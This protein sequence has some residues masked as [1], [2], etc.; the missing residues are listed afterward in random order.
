[1]PRLTKQKPTPL[2]TEPDRALSRVLFRKNAWILGVAAGVILVLFLLVQHNSNKRAAF[3]EADQGADSPDAIIEK[4]HL[5]STALAQKHWELYATSAKLYQNL[6]RADTEDIYAEY[7][8]NNRMVSN[9]TADK[10]QINT[11]TNATLV[12]G[13]VELITENGSKL[14]TDKLAW[15]PD[16]DQIRTNEKVHVYKGSDDITAVGLVADT[17][18]NNIQF[19]K[20]VHTQVRDTNEIENFNRRKPF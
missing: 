2:I 11:E 6:K 16:T 12:E 4:F 1:V 7:Y 14:E 9:L 5:I 19:A 15:D 17:Q 3:E 10:A 18:L 13:H 8:K 20:D